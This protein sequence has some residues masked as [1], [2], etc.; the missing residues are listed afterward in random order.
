MERTIM[1]ED[2]NSFLSVTFR[3]RKVSGEAEDFN[4]TSNKID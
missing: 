3:T 4:S 1:L 2:F